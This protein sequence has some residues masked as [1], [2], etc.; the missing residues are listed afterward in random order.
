MGEGGCVLA[1]CLCTTAR[2][3]IGHSDVMEAGAKVLSDLT[4]VRGK[5]NLKRAGVFAGE[6]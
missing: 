4:D 5:C 1:E 2:R 3:V 6:R